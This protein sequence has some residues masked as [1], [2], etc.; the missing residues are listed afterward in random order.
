VRNGSIEGFDTGLSTAP[1]G[2]R[3]VAVTNVVFTDNNVTGAIVTGDGESVVRR[4]TSVANGGHGI[5]VNARSAEN[6]VSVRNDLTG[7][8]VSASGRSTDVLGNVSV[9][10]GES[11]FIVGR[12]GSTLTSNRAFAND[13]EGIRSSVRVTY[14]RNVASGNT[15][16]GLLVDGDSNS[17]LVRNRAHGNGWPVDDGVGGG[18]I[19]DGSGLTVTGDAN[20]ALGNDAANCEGGLCG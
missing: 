9:G 4:L 11:G 8:F 14:E 13:E 15:F 20:A 16:D 19:I 10:N 12:V 7:L 1:A 5:L 3:D 18:I 17:H 6:N 2:V